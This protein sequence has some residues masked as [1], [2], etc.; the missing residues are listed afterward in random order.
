MCSPIRCYAKRGS[1]H[2]IDRL[3]ELAGELAYSTTTSNNQ[4]TSYNS[5]APLEK[6]VGRGARAGSRT[7]RQDRTGRQEQKTPP[8]NSPRKR[9]EARTRAKDDSLPADYNIQF[10]YN[11]EWAHAGLCRKRG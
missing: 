4:V 3:R 9:N 10:C 8:A 7:R 11:C 5:A 1:K 2:G 6:N